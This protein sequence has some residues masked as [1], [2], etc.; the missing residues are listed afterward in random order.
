MLTR[1]TTARFHVSRH[2]CENWLVWQAFYP[3]VNW[4][5]QVWWH[6]P[7]ISARKHKEDLKFLASLSFINRQHSSDLPTTTK[8]LIAEGHRKGQCWTDKKV[9][10]STEIRLVIL[11]SLC[12]CLQPLTTAR[13]PH[14]KYELKFWCHQWLNMWLQL[15]SILWHLSSFTKGLN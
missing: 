6:M 14:I 5:H 8:S 15:Q 1:P 11:A 2:Q 10:P 4:W 12:I 7:V 3:T 9:V 13:I